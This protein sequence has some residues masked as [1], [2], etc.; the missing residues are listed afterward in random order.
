MENLASMLT[1]VAYTSTATFGIACNLFYAFENVRYAGPSFRIIAI[2][3][4]AIAVPTA[5][6]LILLPIWGIA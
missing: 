2:I 1:L 4:L 3:S 5:L 6:S